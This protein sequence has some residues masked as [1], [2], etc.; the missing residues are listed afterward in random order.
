MWKLDGTED[1]II[2]LQSNMKDQKWW[3]ML[4]NGLLFFKIF[5]VLIYFSRKMLSAMKKKPLMHL[6]KMH[7]NLSK[8]IQM[9]PQLLEKVFNALN[10]FILIF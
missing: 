2:Y 9:S 3:I 7:L 10:D 4:K 8:K 1:A 6:L 5:D